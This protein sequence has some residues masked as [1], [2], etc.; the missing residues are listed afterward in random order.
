MGRAGESKGG[1]GDNCNRTTIKK[2]IQ[3]I[4]KL[5]LKKE[6]Q[7]ESCPDCLK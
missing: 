7:T 4:N 6:I 2:L 1:N 5:F 3:K